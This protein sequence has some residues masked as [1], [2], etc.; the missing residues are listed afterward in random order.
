MKV[1]LGNYVIDWKSG[2]TEEELRVFDETVY[3]G[4]FTLG[5]LDQEPSDLNSAMSKVK[6]VRALIEKGGIP[7][8]MGWSAMKAVGVATGTYELCPGDDV[9]VKAIAAGVAVATMLVGSPTFVGPVLF[10]AKKHGPRAWKSIT[11]PKP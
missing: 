4:D 6:T 8:A 11:S 5:D 10:L 2:P 3:H 1:D 9:Q 7:L